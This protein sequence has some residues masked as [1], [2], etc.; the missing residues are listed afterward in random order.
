MPE[1]DPAIEDGPSDPEPLAERLREAAVVAELET[2]RREETVVE[3]RR[4][5]FRRLARM[6]FGSLLLVAGV[7]MLV[8]PGPG[9]LVIAA[10]LAVLSRDVAWAE[11]VLEKVRKRIPGAQPDGKLSPAAW[12]S[13]ICVTLAATSASIWFM[14]R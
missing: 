1:D 6:F 12:A 10:G 14:L 5:I 3:V 2:G 11:R 8:L 13:V 4:Q 7:L 9:W